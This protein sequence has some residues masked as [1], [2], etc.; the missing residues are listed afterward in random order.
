M[1]NPVENAV[2]EEHIFIS[3]DETV[4][5]LASLNPSVGSIE[6]A[7]VNPSSEGYNI[8]GTDQ[9]DNVKSICLETSA[10][11]YNAAQSNLSSRVHLE[12]YQSEATIVDT[13]SA[14]SPKAEAEVVSQEGDA[15]IKREV[16]EVSL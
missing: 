5:E 9:P 11:D 6:E 1:F 7:T 16:P 15:P 10:A 2:D 8:D 13:A 12:D 14:L 4:G 3:S